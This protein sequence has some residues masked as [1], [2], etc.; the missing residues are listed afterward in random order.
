[1]M[2]ENNLY[3]KSIL[4]NTF[5]QSWFYP[6]LWMI[7]PSQHRFVDAFRQT[8]CWDNFLNSC[9]HH[10]K[11]FVLVARFFFNI[12]SME[13]SWSSSPLQHLHGF[14]LIL[15]KLPTPPLHQPGRLCTKIS[16]DG[17]MQKLLRQKF[18]HMV[19]KRKIV[20]ILQMVECWEKPFTKKECFHWHFLHSP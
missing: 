1:M 16:Q 9:M 12:Y 6:P 8:S 13:K 11:Y 19:K 20:E 5:N 7:Y 10:S 14:E 17:W 2:F 4:C 18:V 15:Q 3:W